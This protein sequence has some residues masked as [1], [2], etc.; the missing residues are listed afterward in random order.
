MDCFACSSAASAAITVVVAAI[1]IIKN[2]T[3]KLEQKIQSIRIACEIIFGFPFS[4]NIYFVNSSLSLSSTTFLRFYMWRMW[5]TCLY[6]CVAI[7]ILCVLLCQTTNK[8]HKYRDDID[9]SFG[10]GWLSVARTQYI[11]MAHMRIRHGDEYRVVPV[12]SIEN[13]CWCFRVCCLL[14]RTLYLDKWRLINKWRHHTECIQVW[15]LFWILLLFLS[16][17][18]QSKRVG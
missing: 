8:S 2:D 1:Y 3:F 14:V 6:F 7:N 18:N 9:N 10:G 5:R 15:I 4:L 17:L 13:N 11:Y 12:K 16:K